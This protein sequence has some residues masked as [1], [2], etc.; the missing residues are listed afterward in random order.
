[1]MERNKPNLCAIPGC[2]GKVKYNNAGPLQ[3]MCPYH[4]TLITVT[5]SNSHLTDSRNT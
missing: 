4:Y 2:G 1:M 3:K 5:A